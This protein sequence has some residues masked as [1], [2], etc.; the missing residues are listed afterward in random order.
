MVC[1]NLKIW[2][3]EGYENDW[4]EFRGTL[5]KLSHTQIK[6]IPF[7]DV[8]EREIFKRK[9]EADQII[10]MKIVKMPDTGI[11]YFLLLLQNYV[12]LLL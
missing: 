10:A 6:A 2:K 12:T 8:K 11:Y 1:D 7:T 9:L 3:A 5:T 4:H